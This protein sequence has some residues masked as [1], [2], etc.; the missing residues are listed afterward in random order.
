MAWSAIP[1]HTRK[2]AIM[3][4][5]TFSFT[6]AFAISVRT[7]MMSNFLATPHNQPSSNLVDDIKITYLSIC[8][9]IS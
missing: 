5:I 1:Q 4:R 8:S 6:A 3:I 9:A 2:V 7:G